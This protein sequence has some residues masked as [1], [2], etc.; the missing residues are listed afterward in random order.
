MGVIVAGKLILAS[1]SPRRIELLRLM[2]L[3]FEVMPSSIEEMP[4]KG[5]SPVE[6]VLGLSRQKANAI[7]SRY[8]DVWIL[9]A[10]TIVVVNGEM[11][12]KPA[13]ASEAREMLARLSGREHY[14]HT[15]F[16]IARK[17]AD[18][19]LGDVVTSSVLFKNISEEE[20]NWYVRTEEPYDKAGGYAVQGAGA[21]FIREIHGSYTNVIG[22]PLCEAVSLLKRA[23]AIEFPR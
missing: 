23:G 11:M 5:E 22:L 7:S 13:H 19:L 4:Q 9:G 1:E 6:H 21:M 18:V 16:T 20:I 12:G 15:G 8:P 10:D 3:D 14:V 2:G 17:T